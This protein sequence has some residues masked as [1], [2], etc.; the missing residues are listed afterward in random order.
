[1]KNL[2]V[3]MES[4]ARRPTVLRFSPT[5]WAKLLFLRDMGDS[6]IGAFGISAQDDLLYVE[7]VRLVSQT[8]TWVHVEFDD[9][10]VANFF[11]DQVDAGQRPETFGRL[12]LHTHPGNSPEPS[13][14]DEETFSR[15]FGRAEWAVM[16]ILAR[17]GQTYARLRY[18]VGPSAEIKIPVEID[19]SR[20]FDSTNFEAWEHEYL[21]H[22]RL[23]PE[24]PPN[25]PKA[26]RDALPTSN[27][28]LFQDD[29]R[30]QAWEDYLDFEHSHREEDYGY[31]SD[32]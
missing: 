8:C 14:T 24:D 27:G 26:K 15:V 22:V 5:A 30:R 10:S 4:P 12:W 1:M 11:D 18:N 16:F 31:A 28:D 13:L 6:E 29:W 25:I 2:K 32:F 19:F 9:E 7:D 3:K 20:P 23:P 21:A 17:G